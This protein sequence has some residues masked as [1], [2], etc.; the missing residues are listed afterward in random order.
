MKLTGIF[1]ASQVTKST[2]KSLINGDNK[3]ERLS[4]GTNRRKNS[5][6][7]LLLAALTTKNIPTSFFRL[8]SDF[9]DKAS[10]KVPQLSF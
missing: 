2:L 8:L 4:N 7:A 9:F 1:K 6:I 5:S 10:I 3:K